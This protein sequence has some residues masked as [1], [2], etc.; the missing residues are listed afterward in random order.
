MSAEVGHACPAMKCENSVAPDQ[1]M[2]SRHW[3]MV[4]R[5]VRSAV[6]RAWSD[7]AGAGT[8]AHT[9]AISRAIRTVNHRLERNR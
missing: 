2:C 6:W 4:P 1:L 8:P 7:G 9:A 3:Y 5:P